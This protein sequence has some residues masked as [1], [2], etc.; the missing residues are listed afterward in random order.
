MYGR[1]KENRGIKMYNFFI[2]M[3]SILGSIMLI[4]LYFNK[5][6]SW[7]L[8]IKIFIVSLAVVELGYFGGNFL[9]GLSYGE[10]RGVSDIIVLFTGKN[11]NHFLGRVIFTMWIFPPLFC[12]V[13]K[14]IREEWI[15]YL[16]ILC[17]FLSFQHIFNRLGCL[18]NGCC[19]G[20]Y[21]NGIFALKYNVN[22][23]NGPGY[24]YPVYPT[25]M[26]EIIC[27]I[28]LFT[29]LFILHLKNKR[30]V[31][32][33]QVGFAITIFISEFMMNSQGVMIVCGLTVIQYGAIVL[34]ITS[35]VM[36]RIRKHQISE[37]GCW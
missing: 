16:D 34:L 9:R 25:Q 6:R 27:M 23:K 29:I 36:W 30:L 4:F 1:N 14:D 35:F 2:N 3:G 22:G 20:K 13:L 33:F 26:F 28:I 7:K 15:N 17:I 31:Y 10:I 18:F 5:S 8:T 37:E 12:I 11:G 19:C 32:I 21:Y 24:S